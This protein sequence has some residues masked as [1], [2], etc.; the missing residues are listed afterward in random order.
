MFKYI[1]FTI[2]YI[3]LILNEDDIDENFKKPY[4][5]LA[6]YDSTLVATVTNDEFSDLFF[7]DREDD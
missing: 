6:K 2:I 5:K 1:T 4:I 7:Y 3:K